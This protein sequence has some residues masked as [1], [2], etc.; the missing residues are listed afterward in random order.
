MNAAK[1]GVLCWAA[2]DLD[3]PH[4][5]L[6]VQNVCELVKE[7]NKETRFSGLPLG[8][9]DADITANQ[10]CTWQTGFPL[11]I[12]LAGGRP[13]YDPRQ[14]RTA[15]VLE[16][17]EADTL[18]WVSSYRKE[19]TPPETN[20]PS[21]VLGHAGMKFKTEPQVYIPVA[22]PGIDHAGHIFRSDNVVA[23]PLRALRNTK[24][25]SAEEIVCAI[26][27]QLLSRLKHNHVD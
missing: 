14:H 16:R 13:D 26:E 19:R 4:A 6:T 8:G 18:L 21:I 22:T 17:D 24:L 15:T 10:V 12:S 23:L 2:A 5:E 7:L 27:N 9:N 11:P 3:F 1:Y 25:P 20:I